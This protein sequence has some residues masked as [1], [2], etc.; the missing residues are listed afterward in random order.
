MASSRLELWL[1]DT[2]PGL[3]RR[4]AAIA[5]RLFEDKPVGVF[6]L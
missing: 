5:Q 6:E 3:S 2:T 1:H 4:L